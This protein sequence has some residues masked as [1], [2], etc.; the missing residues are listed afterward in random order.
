MKLQE[1]ARWYAATHDLAVSSE[2]MYVKHAKLFAK[3]IGNPDI[4]IA[5]VTPEMLALHLRAMR[6]AGKADSYRRSRRSHL[7]ALLNS[8][9]SDA[10]LQRR[11]KPF[12][13]RTVPGVRIKDYQPHGMRL[14]DV[15]ALLVA[16]DALKGDYSN[17]IPRKKWWR[18]W[19]RVEWESGLS[20]CD[21]LALHRHSINSDGMCE[22][23][24]IKTGARVCFQLR[25]KTIESLDATYPPN[26]ALCFPLWASLEMLR[27][28]FAALRA[29]AGMHE[30]SMKWLRAGSGS[31]VEQQK[32][33]T[34]HCH[35]GN[36][37]QV[38]NRHYRIDSIV[39]PDIPLPPDPESA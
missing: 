32:P 11:P 39:R 22:A 23:V 19:I 14:T 3:D 29:K 33:G 4:D 37:V 21:M 2:R 35:L 38:F 24:R 27:R 17:G 31:Y 16:A 20:P 15:Q 28:E 26:R 12:L 1:Y 36:T 18:A 13:S 10:E 30:G 5:D 8:A 6:V 25:P 34:G 7:I 9:S